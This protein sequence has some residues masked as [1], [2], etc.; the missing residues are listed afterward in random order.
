MRFV[1]VKKTLAKTLAEMM[2][3]GVL[4]FGGCLWLFF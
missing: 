1:T 4:I 3:K 2:V